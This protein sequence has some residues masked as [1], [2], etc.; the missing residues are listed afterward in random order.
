ML[1]YQRDRLPAF[2]DSSSSSGNEG[3]SEADNET[4]F[5]VGLKYKSKRIKNFLESLR[6][7]QPKTELDR[8]LLLGIIERGEPSNNTRLKRKTTTENLA[9]SSSYNS[10]THS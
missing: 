5:D 9:V 7:F 8:Q 6:G 1:Y 3:A 2:S 4:E 10:N